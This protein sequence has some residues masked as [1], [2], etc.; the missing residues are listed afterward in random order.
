[1]TTQTK[2]LKKGVEGYFKMTVIKSYILLLL[3][4]GEGCFKNCSKLCDAIYE[5]PLTN[6]NKNRFEF[7]IKT[8]IY[9]KLD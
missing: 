7:D 6:R 2:K 3:W 4:C 8:R 5:W 1:M 9:S